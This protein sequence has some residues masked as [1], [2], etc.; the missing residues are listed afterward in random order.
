MYV[1]NERSDI[2]STM[3]NDEDFSHIGHYFDSLGLQETVGG[4]FATYIESV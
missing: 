3:K 2:V 4:I 1:S